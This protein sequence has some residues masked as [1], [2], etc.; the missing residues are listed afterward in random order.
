MKMKETNQHIKVLIARYVSG[1]ASVNE[2]AEL[3]DW[4]KANNANKSLFKKLK[5]ELET[6]DEMQAEDEWVR[7]ANKFELEKKVTNKSRRLIGF[8]S[9][10]ASISIV[11][12]VASQLFNSSDTDYLSMLNTNELKGTNT[13]LRLADGQ[14]ITLNENHSSIEADKDGKQFVVEKNQIVENKIE[15]K[16]QHKLNQI[17]VPYGKT[18]QLALADGTK[19]W[20][21]AGS[22]LVFPNHFNGTDS[23]DVMLLGEG[24]FDVTHN[25]G[26]PFRVLTNELTYTVLGTSFNIRSY[27]GSAVNSAVL[28]EGSLQVEEN[29]VFNKE[30]VILKPG[31]KSL[32]VNN[33]GQLDVQHVNTSIY[34]SWKEGF[35]TL[36]KNN[37]RTLIHQIEHYYNCDIAI[38][39]E[40]LKMPTQLSGKL[41]LDTNAEQVYQAL[42]DL[43]GLSYSIE[44][45]QVKFYKE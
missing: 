11:L 27:A 9:I 8:V 21:N 33:S 3:G 6:K 1:M 5:S 2:I 15:D 18:A 25:E 44:N 7:F 24:F 36:E 32:F 40:L 38:S 37:L 12:V 29:A 23:R 39:N 41:M 26:Q 31:E 45:N 43:S 35:L 42:C 16:E 30:R 14:Q 17:Q 28:V 22:Q 4:L 10:A 19:V 20:L 13:V 34:T